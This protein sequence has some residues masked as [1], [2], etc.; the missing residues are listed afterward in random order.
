VG[1]E[2][3]A[4]LPSLGGDARVRGRVYHRDS[5]VVGGAR[6]FAEAG[7][8]RDLGGARVDAGLRHVHDVADAGGEAASDQV[9]I[10]AARGFLDDRL[11]LRLAREQALSG[12][13]DVLEFPTRTLVR[14]DWRINPA[15]TAYVA[16]EWLESG[17]RR[18]SLNRVGVRG[19]PWGGAQVN[20]SADQFGSTAGGRLGL[21]YGFTQALQ[22]VERWT[23][24]AG[25]QRRD[26]LKGDQ[27]A[28]AASSL[29]FGEGGTVG[30][31]FTAA[32]AAVSAQLRQAV[33]SARIEGRRAPSGEKLNLLAYYHQTKEEGLVYGG[34]LRLSRDDTS[35]VAEGLR[36]EMRLGLAYRSDDGPVLLSRLDVEREI[37][38]GATVLPD[39]QTATKVISNSVLNL[40][41]QEADELSIYLG[42]KVAR[43][44]YAGEDEVTLSNLVAV[45]YRRALVGRFDVG[46]RAAALRIGGEPLAYALAPSLGVSL[47]DAIWVSAGYNWGRVHDDDFGGAGLSHDGAFVRFRL[48]FDEMNVRQLLDRF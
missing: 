28:P 13:D 19:S 35:G 12:R 1:V 33:F 46:L 10:G 22:L 29:R 27:S 40:P 47:G 41:L 11:T 5:A 15:S 44:E 8:A 21:S 32:H 25:F 16:H 17:P 7:V 3:A 6:T 42:A 18:G 37:F 43:D 9:L 31:D 45:E 30:E 14:A 39:S 2:G 20:A 24:S 34:R 23:L 38:A 26:G 48:K 4:N 36:G